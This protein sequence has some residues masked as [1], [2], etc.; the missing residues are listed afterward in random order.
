MYALSFAKRPAEELFDL[1][2]DPEQLNNVADDPTFAEIKK[3]LSMHLTAELNA[4]GDPRIIGG[5]DFD[6]FPYLGGGPK[7]PDWRK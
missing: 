3:R 2:K 7:H 4:T 6:A 5:V 1:S